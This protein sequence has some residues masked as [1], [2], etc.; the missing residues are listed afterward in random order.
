MYFKLQLDTLSAHCIARTMYFV[1]EVDQHNFDAVYKMRNE[2]S[3]TGKKLS[4]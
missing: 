3:I 1:I 2:C 4:K